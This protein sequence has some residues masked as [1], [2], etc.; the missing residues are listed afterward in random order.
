[1]IQQEEQHERQQRRGGITRG[2]V[3]QKMFTFRIDFDVLEWL[4]AHTTN[5]GRFINDSLR[6]VIASR[7]E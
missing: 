3:R 2:E 7:E 6:E 5:K 4:A 1:M